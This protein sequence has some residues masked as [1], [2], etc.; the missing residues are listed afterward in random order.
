ME[1]YDAI[2]IG[3]GNGGLTAS[4][5]M[6]QKGLNVLLLERHNIP[7]GCATSFCRGRFEF[8]VALH[9]LSG[10]GTEEKP[11]PIRNLLG[12]LGV[13]ESLELVEMDDLYRVVMPGRLDLTLKADRAVAVEELQRQFPAEREAIEGFF[14]LVYKF[15]GE[16]LSVFYFRDPEA[17][18]DKYPI[19]YQYVF[20][21]AKEVLDAYFSDPL[22]KAVLA[23]YWGYLGVP[24]NRLSFAYVALLYYTYLEFKPFHMKGG[25]QTLSN[26]LASKMQE[27]GGTVRFNCGVRQILVEDGAVR[28]VVTDDGER[29]PARVVVSNASQVATYVQLIEAGQIPTDVRMELRGRELSPSAFIVFMGLDCEPDAVQIPVTTNFILTHTDIDERPLE[30]MRQ[31]ATG[32]DLMV[33]SC[34][35]VADPSFSPPGTSQCNCVTLK[36]GAP[37]MRIPPS[38]Y[39]ETK[40]RC[41]EA[42]LQTVEKAFPGIRGHIEEAEV[43]TPL[44]MMR[45]LG[46]P[47]GAIYGYDQQTKDSLFFQASRR[48]PIQGLF[49]AGGWVG[50]CGFQPTLESGKAVARSVLKH[51]SDQ[52]GGTA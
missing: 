42:M 31:V 41:A 46:H 9:Q 47:G 14:D 7:G 50:D 28:G 44:T 43:A 37:W 20:R 24:P 15:A 32:N 11:G 12:S 29:V 2:V 48:S 30:E 4:A 5:A 1:G 34:Y 22:L 13:L 35:D 36:F 17:S 40:Y 27:A 49:F 3:A 23:V 45:Y 25:S 19:L 51:L 39:Y 10:L 26:A 8:E 38:A 6:A 16:M 18:R 52:A 21:N 33:L